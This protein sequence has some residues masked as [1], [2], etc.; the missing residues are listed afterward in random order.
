MHPKV[1]Q[2]LSIVLA[3]VAL[4][5]RLLSVNEDICTKRWSAI[6]AITIALGCWSHLVLHAL[7]SILDGVIEDEGI[8]ERIKDWLDLL[9]QIG[10]DF[11]YTALWIG[12]DCH[13][14]Q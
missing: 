9:W 13:P 1:F 6:I 10:M 7:K 11:A 4:V 14:P 3:G 2:L 5:L 8:N 12:A